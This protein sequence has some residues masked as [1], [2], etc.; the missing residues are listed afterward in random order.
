MKL[1]CSK[2]SLYEAIIN[3]SKAV[4]ERSSLPSLEGIKCKISGTTMELTGYNLEIGIRTNISVVTQDSGEFILNA[5][6]F[7]DIVR[8]MPEEDIYIEI[9]DNY[10]VTLSSGVTTFN[11]SAISSEDY[12]ELPDKNNSEEIVFSQALL[13]SMINQTIF[14]VAITDMKP[15]LKGELFE[16]ENGMLSLVSI[17]GYRLAVRQEPIKYNDNIKFVVPAKALVE[18]AKLL[19][20]DEEDNCSMFVSS[21]HIIFE[22]NGYFVYSRLLEGEFHPYKSAIPDTFTTEV[23]ADRRNLIDTL[24]RAMLLINER[25]PSPVRCYFE[26]DIIKVR[27]STSMGKISDEISADIAGP[28]IEIGFKCKYFLD[29]LKV[30]DDDKVKLQM[31]G[32]LLP[33]KIV[34][35]DDSNYTFLVLPVRLSK[36]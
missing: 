25:N 7:G 32:S 14:A 4:S 19:S 26:N 23:I 27:C 8:K 12:P 21:K 30:I 5:R 3:V 13:K 18:V 1:K 2:T 9:N 22:I 6:L 11:M 10:Q 17:D 20:D 28:V 35:C 33:M 24:E 16:I 31:S 29:P 15:I 34:P 36:E